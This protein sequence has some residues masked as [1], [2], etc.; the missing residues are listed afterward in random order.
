EEDKI[1]LAKSFMEK[2][3]EKGVHFY[4]QT[5]A[6]IADEF[7]K[8]ANVK[9]VAADE[10]TPGWMCLDIGED[11]A[12]THTEVIKESKLIVWN[13]PMGV[14]ELDPFANGT[15]TVA[16]ALAEPAGYSVIGGGDSAAAVEQFGVAV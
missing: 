15:K 7:N 16:N 1:D 9:N 3:K 10:I 8:D 12:K 14:F 5:D 13:G 4:I 11:T 2:A 6:V